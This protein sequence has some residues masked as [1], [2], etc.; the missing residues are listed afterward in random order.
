M[1]RISL[2]AQTMPPENKKAM[3]RQLEKIDEGIKQ[4][5]YK[6]EWENLEKHEEAPEWFLD[7]K[8][9]IYFHWGVYTVPGVHAWYLRKM[10]LP[11]TDRKS[12]QKYHTETY[13]TPAE[14]PYH[15]FAPQFK[16]EK[17]DPE[18]WAE[19]FKAAGARF[20]GPCAIHHDG[21]AMW[22][23]DITPWC[24]GKEGPK[25][26]IVGLLE[27][28]IRKRDMK[29]ITTFHN[30][31]SHVWIPRV[32]GTPTVSID[33]YMRMVYS[34]HTVDEYGKIFLAELGEVIDKYRPDLIWFDA[35]MPEIRPDIIHR[36]FLAYYFN[37]AHT[38]NNK[39]VINTKHLNYP[40]EI[41]VED[42]E[43]G[44]SHRL[45]KN[46]WISDDT[47]GSGWMYRNAKKP[48]KMRETRDVIQGF[49][50]IISKN[51]L[52]LLNVAPTVEGLIPEPQ[53][54]MLKEIGEWLKINGEGVYE[55]RPWLAFGEGPNRRT[56]SGRG[57]KSMKKLT[58]EDVRYTRSKD[59]STLYAFIMGWNKEYVLK[60]VKVN[61]K[62]G[63]VELLGH[64]KVEHRVNNEGQIIIK[65]PDLEREERPCQYAFCFKLTGFD[66]GLHPD[67]D[68]TWQM[69][70][71]VKVENH[72]SVIGK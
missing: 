43:K 3:L 37:Q 31:R 72:H 28:A 16:A 1:H 46:P 48:Y 34:N 52:L 64:G 21:F 66:I 7:A 47:V 49:I 63:K 35:E 2:P 54:K 13:G 56:Q 38:W 60:S 55:T 14:Y 33:P 57:R 8:L 29:F 44:G 39:V 62:D 22:D 11:E 36:K 24:A 71:S 59:N 20:A 70:D 10:H 41:A 19:L 69:T 6:A 18:H 26:D 68:K 27:K 23:S 40:N 65:F 67:V 51:G 61:N 9:G 15:K 53:Q 32:E 25:K 4:G 5:P 42:F 58:K 50:S 45:T 12:E 17:F 30:E